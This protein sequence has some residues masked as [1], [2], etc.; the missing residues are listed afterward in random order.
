MR[1][2]T[3]LLR[4]L[5]PLLVLQFSHLMLIGTRTIPFVLNRNAVFGLSVENNVIFILSIVII[6]FVI[7]EYVRMDSHRAFEL[8]IVGG[9]SNIVDRIVWGGVVDYVAF[10]SFP[11]FNIPDVLISIGIVWY[12]FDTIKYELIK[13]NESKNQGK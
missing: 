10:Y 5:L 13:H 12:V 9:L 7:Y 8:I 1:Y 4:I 2:L 3:F 11:V 6:G